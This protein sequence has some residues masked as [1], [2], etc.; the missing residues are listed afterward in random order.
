MAVSLRYERGMFVLGA[1]RGDGERGDDITANLRTVRGIPLVLDD[2]APDL[3]EVR[4]EVYMTNSE[5]LRLNEL[6]PPPGNCPSP[7]RGTPRP[8]RSS[9]ST[10]GSAP[11]RRLRF[12]SHGLGESEGVAEVVSRDPQLLKGWGIPVSPHTPR[13]DT[14]DAGDRPRRALA[15][16]SEHARVPDRRARGQGRRPRPAGAA[17]DRSKSPRWVIAYQIRGRAGDHEDLRISVQV[18]KTGKLTP[19]ADL[20]PVPLA[21]TTVKR[22]SL[23]N[24]D[25]IA[26]K[27]VRVVTRS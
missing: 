24:A 7:T 14:I 17:R 15:R 8:A 2:D 11:Q 27:D 1:T 6:G 4:G 5:L 10:R 23:H 25:E 22:A 19:V 18:G 3:L 12:V 21:G 20:A 26:R 16:R 13:Y 9:C